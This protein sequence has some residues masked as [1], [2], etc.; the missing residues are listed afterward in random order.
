[1]PGGTRGESGERS[2]S[3]KELK[4]FVGNV[5]A[6]IVNEW[7]LEKAEFTFMCKFKQGNHVFPYSNALIINMI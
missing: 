7:Q 3:F 2:N 6:A 4:L 5:F 1:M